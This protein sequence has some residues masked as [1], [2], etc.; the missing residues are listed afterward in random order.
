[1]VDSRDNRAAVLQSRLQQLGEQPVFGAAEAE[2]DDVRVL[3]DC[4]V[5]RL[6]QAQSVA[7]RGG[8][9]LPASAKAE[10]ARAGRDSGNANSVISFGCDNPRDSGPML[11]DRDSSSGDEV[12]V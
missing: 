2:I 3:L 12:A 11:L 9:L 8:P 7:D 10:Q 1:M 4:E 5:D 6:G